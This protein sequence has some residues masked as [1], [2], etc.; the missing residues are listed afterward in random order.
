M[1]CSGLVEK[2]KKNDQEKELKKV[3]E[4]QEDKNQQ[5][6]QL[7]SRTKIRKV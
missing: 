1:Y 5:E 6:K 4:E 3:Q 7:K 2:E